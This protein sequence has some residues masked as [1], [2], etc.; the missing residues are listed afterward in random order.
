MATR[1]RSDKCVIP[2][3]IKTTIGR[4]VVVI[5]AEAEPSKKIHFTSGLI[6][7]IRSALL[8]YIRY[9]KSDS[10]DTKMWD[11]L[12]S[13]LQY[14]ATG[15]PKLIERQYDAIRVQ[16]VALE[17]HR[18]HNAE[19]NPSYDSSLWE[20]EYETFDLL[21]D[22]YE[23]MKAR[24]NWQQANKTYFTNQ[25]AWEISNAMLADIFDSLVDIANKRD[26]IV[27]P[28][29]TYFSI[30]EL[31]NYGATKPLGGDRDDD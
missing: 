7:E 4:L 20:S 22:Y 13:M 23:V 28:K 30:D 8:I 25:N 12:H 17:K 21:R 29:N 15:N 5:S 3:T 26:L 16:F 2:E 14:K 31:N 24:K 18:I 19:H 6:G 27:I 9:W 10:V 1:S 11:L